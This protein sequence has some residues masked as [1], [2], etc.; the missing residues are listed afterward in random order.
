[1]L[2]LEQERRMTS[3]ADSIG[4]VIGVDT[5]KPTH[6]I[7]VWIEAEGYASLARSRANP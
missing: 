5:H 4:S 6:S 7:A 2:D 1:M 3:V